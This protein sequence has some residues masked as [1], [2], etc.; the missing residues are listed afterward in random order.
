MVLVLAL[1]SGFAAEGVRWTDFR[2][3]TATNGWLVAGTSY[4]SDRGL[5]FAE[6]GACAQRADWAGAVTSVVVVTYCSGARL[7]SP[8][9]LEAGRTPDGLAACSPPIA[10]VYTRY[11][12]N[13]FAFAEANGVHAL[14]LRLNAEGEVKGNYY[15][16]ALGVGSVDEAPG[17]VA[18]PG[19]GEGSGATEG[20]ADEAAGTLWRVSEFAG[21]TRDE[22]FAWVLG[23]TKATPWEN[24]VTIPGFHAFKNGVAVTSVGRDSGRAT[25]AGLYASRGAEGEWPRT[26]SLL[27]SSGAGV[28]LELGVLNDGR[29][30]LGGARVS[31]D[32]CQ[33]TFPESEPRALSLSWAVTRDAARPAEGAWRTNGA[34]DYPSRPGPAPE[35][36]AVVVAPQAAYASGVLVPAGG[37]LWLRWSVPRQAGSP[38][39]GVGRLRVELF[40]RF[41]TALILR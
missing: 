6:T 41:G 25:V 3:K 8:F 31:Y 32:A 1:L 17:E 13:T 37:V 5:K 4:S 21:G 40:K 29:E 24:G 14:R 27:G 38:M 19:G 34:A 35:G 39:L 33:W 26:L 30:P 36:Q 20:G 9:I 23:V 16:T 18:P 7:D 28:S 10:Y 12:T 22:D 11:V 2:Q 15:V